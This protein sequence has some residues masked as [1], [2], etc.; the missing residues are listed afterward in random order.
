MTSLRS[1][2][3]AVFVALGIVAMVGLIAKTIVDSAQQEA[4]TVESPP[5]PANAKRLNWQTT[6][7]SMRDPE[8]GRAFYVVT[9]HNGGV[10]VAFAPSPPEE[11]NDCPNPTMADHPKAIIESVTEWKERF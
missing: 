1:Y 10:A 6:M 8:S 2:L 4:R 5:L 11:E 9:N 7:F 3:A